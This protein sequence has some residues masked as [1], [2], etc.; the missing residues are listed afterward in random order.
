[1]SEACFKVGCQKPMTWDPEAVGRTVGG[2]ELRGAWVCECGAKAL[3]DDSI[4]NEKW[5][6]VSGG[7]SVDTGTGRIRIEGAG[8]ATEDLILRIARLPELEALE[9]RV[10]ADAKLPTT[11]ARFAPKR[12]YS[13][14]KTK[15]SKR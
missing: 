3:G 12:M 1:M 11:G 7:R 4:P 15:G 8:D 10:L 2:L 5:S 9:R 14:R 13:A 6:I